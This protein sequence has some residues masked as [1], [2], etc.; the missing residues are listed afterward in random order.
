MQ[1]DNFIM[2]P[3]NKGILGCICDIP[4]KTCIYETRPDGLDGIYTG[5][6]T[7]ISFDKIACIGVVYG[8]LYRIW[9]DY[10]KDISKC[11][12]W[13]DMGYD[14]IFESMFPEYKWNGLNESC[15]RKWKRGYDEIFAYLGK[16]GMGYRIKGGI[17][18]KY[19]EVY[20]DKI[21]ENEKIDMGY[22]IKLRGNGL[23]EYTCGKGNG[24]LRAV[25]IKPWELK[26][27]KFFEKGGYNHGIQRIY[28]LWNMFYK[29][30]W[31]KRGIWKGKPY[32]D[33]KDMKY[34][35][36]G[37]VLKQGRMVNEV[38]EKI[39][40]SF[41]S[42]EGKQVIKICGFEKIR[43]GKWNWEV[44][45]GKGWKDV[46]GKDRYGNYYDIP[47]KDLTGE[48]QDEKRNMGLINQVNGKHFVYLGNDRIQ[49]S[50]SVIYRM[51][52]DNKVYTGKYGRNYSFGNGF[53]NV[54]SADRLRMRID[55]EKVNE[56]DFSGLHIRMLYALVGKEY[57]KNDIYDLGNWYV[58]Y[59]LDM[60]TQRMA[61][62][63]MILIMI[64]APSRSK[65]WFAFKK[66][67]NELN[68]T[69]GYHRIAWTDE[70]IDTIEREHKDIARY[71]CSGKGVELQWLDGKL[72]RDICCHFSRKDICALPVHDSLVIQE[73]YVNEAIEVMETE[74]GKMFGNRKCPVKVKKI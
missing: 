33:T 40:R 64:N 46:I 60:K 10:D 61:V 21:L 42:R 20:W 72:M 14:E 19:D 9:N 11:P 1:N 12:I 51:D 15:R 59:G 65:A 74:Y 38:I 37:A 69:H 18:R 57:N 16:H 2:I 41:E 53:Q 73:R 36:Q 58:K 13:V 17:F 68:G 55:G 30:Y 44:Y 56:I 6:E 27:K 48:M 45:T 25:Q 50:M 26:L 23:W 35:F 3:Q 32:L 7:H 5:Y 52:G 28:L 49:T 47:E 39:M 8:K 70:L 4:E 71:F 67:W 22:R 43:S 62:K 29:N 34:A 66:E 54:K 63:K 31:C 24:V